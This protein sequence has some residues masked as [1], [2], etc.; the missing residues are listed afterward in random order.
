MKKRRAT[1][2]SF[3]GT[4]RYLLDKFSQSD[5]RT[6]KKFSDGVDE[7]NVRLYYHLE[8]LREIHAEELTSALNGFGSRKRVGK[9]WFRLVDF[10][11]SN[12]FLSTRGSIIKGGRFNIGADLDTRRFPS[13]PALYI[14]ADFDTA[15]SEY[16][17]APMSASVGKFPG[18]EFALVDQ[19]SFTAVKLS[20]ELNNLFDLSKASSLDAF[21]KIIS[22]FKMPDDLK[23][24]YSQI[25]CM[26]I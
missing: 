10:K 13:F 8:S 9:A 4:G 21:S 25:W 1:S 6:W 16:F 12:E 24:S 15:Y 20:F 18:H 11:F 7:Y 14:A 19:G 3:R 2:N 22:K 5:L 17:G 23:T 26:A